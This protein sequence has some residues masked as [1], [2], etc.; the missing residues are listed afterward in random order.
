MTERFDRLADHLAHRV[1]G[2]REISFQIFDDHVD[3]STREKADLHRT[4]FFENP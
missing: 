2:S 1:E 4:F 3:A